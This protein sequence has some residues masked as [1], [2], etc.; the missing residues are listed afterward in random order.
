MAGVGAVVQMAALARIVAAS[1]LHSAAW[2]EVV[3][4]VGVFVV[5][6]AVR[7]A[8]TWG[9]EVAGARAAVGVKRAVRETL[10]E[11]L[12]HAG[13]VALTGEHRGEIATTVTEGVEALDDYV[14]H[15]LPAVALA[16]AVPITVVAAVWTRDLLSAGILV[17]TAPFIPFLMWLI[18]QAAA[19]LARKQFVKMQ[20]LGARML[21][22]LQ[23][24]ASLR[25]LG[26]GR[27]EVQAI[28]AVSEAFAGATLGVLKV[29][30]LSALVL[31][32]IATLATAVVAVTLGIRVL[33]GQLGFEA[34]FWVLLLAPEFYAPLRTLGARFHAKAAA[35][36]SLLRIAELLSLPQLA[37]GEGDLEVP[38]GVTASTVTLTGVSYQYPGADSPAVQGIDL[39]LLPGRRVA[40]VGPSG[41][42]KSTLAA[43]VAGLCDPHDGEVELDG[44]P[45][46][47]AARTAWWRRVVWLP[48]TPHVVHGT[49]ADNLRLAAPDAADEALSDALRAARLEDE[50]RAMPGQLQAEVGPGGENLSGGQRQRL[51]LARAMLRDGSLVVLD[52]PTSQQDP[53][54][55]EALR[56]CTERLLKGRSSLVIAH[57]LHTVQDADEILVLDHGEVVERGTHQDLAGRGG[58]YDELLEASHGEQNDSPMPS[59]L[60][61]SMDEDTDAGPAPPIPTRVPTPPPVPAPVGVATLLAQLRPHTPKVALAALAGAATIGSSIGLLGTGGF[62]IATAATTPYVASI[63]LAVA[64]VRA[65]GIAR[66]LLRYAERLVSHALTFELL[67][68]IRVGFVR[69]LEPLAP[70]GLSRHGRGSLVANAVTDVQT[71]EGFY[72]RGAAPPLIAGLVALGTTAF[73]ARYGTAIAV[74]FAL[75]YTATAVMLPLVLRHLARRSGG[76]E[77]KDAGVLQAAVLDSLR[78]LGELLVAGRRTDVRDQLRAHGDRLDT[79]QLRVAHI[80]ALDPALVPLAGHLVVVGLLAVA[81]PAVQVGT[82]SGVSL[83]VL[84]LAALAS[85]EALTPLAAA[86]RQLDEQRAAM[87]RMDAAVAARPEVVDPDPTADV[88]EPWAACPE[89]PPATDAQQAEPVLAMRGVTFTYPERSRPALN[90]VDL[91][92]DAGSRIAL[93]GPSGAGK[94]TVLS[95]LARFRDG[96]DGSIQAFGR[97]L[98]A[99]A[100]DPLR[101][102]LG[103]VEQDPHLITGTVADNLRLARRG[104]T[105]DELRAALDTAQLGDWIA[106]QRAG[107]DTW[108]GE[109]GVRLSAGQRQRLAL[110]RTLLLQPQTLILDEPTAHLDASSESALLDAVFT[111]AG[112]RPLLVITHRLVHMPRFDEIVVLKDGAVA[113]RGRHAALLEQRGPYRA[114]WGIQ[115]DRL[116]RVEQR[117]RA[118]RSRE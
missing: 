80:G 4:A 14:R 77:R 104:A 79:S 95:L 20:R 3:P 75:G 86:A 9:A 107:L 102:R 76:A 45:R 37:E 33:H 21:D 32:L 114:L 91:T 85:F 113:Q 69:R 27:D 70:A 87:G 38:S 78:G 110:A 25:L 101:R 98:R 62:L 11:R 6:A 60:Q 50:V 42:G 34:A 82:L 36:A 28:A 18:G 96:Y 63:R 17:L 92:L 84:S 109:Q 97:D 99:Y 74:V 52:E 35:N 2:A 65:F 8:A 49:V 40:L 24:M 67:T 39:A 51:A 5:A 66:A 83:A 81:V 19:G 26:R 103:I 105:E 1:L 71:L 100:Q 89:P 47:T 58:L 13:P 115:R 16:A 106:E 72:L 108:L 57:R 64:A 56:G 22:A 93:V 73:L 61:G 117:E 12:I 54:L 68:A 15:Y 59:V 31:E 88:P 55:E 10:V 46:T 23:G 116:G 112:R 90:S 48:Q 43:L 29:A 53:G 30:F 94:S 41:S 7:A 118:A 44:V 111:A